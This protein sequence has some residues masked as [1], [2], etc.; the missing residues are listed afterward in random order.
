LLDESILAASEKLRSAGVKAGDCVGLHYPSSIDYIVF[1]YAVWRCGGCLIPL[2]MELA[3]QEKMEICRCLAMDKIISLQRS[4]G[5]FSSL[6]RSQ[7]ARLTSDAEIFAVRT[8]VDCP[9]ALHDLNPA[10]IRFSSGTTGMAKGVVLSHQTVLERITAANDVLQLGPSDRVLWVLSMSYHFTVSIVAYLTYGATIVLPANHFAAAIVEAV[11]AYQASVLYASPMHY[12]LLAEY[13]EAVPLPSLRLAI[14]TTSALST[15][16]SVQF[17]ERYGQP[18]GQALGIIE[19]GLPCIDMT[20]DSQK[21]KSVGR[22][23]PAYELRMNDVG[24]GAE[25][26]EIVVRGPGMLDAY[27]MPWQTRDEILEDGWFHT[28][29][30]GYVDRDGYL[31][32]NGRTKDVINVMGMKFFP[33]E[34]ERVL[35]SHPEVAAASVYSEP[36]GRWGEAVQARVVPHDSARPEHLASRLQTYCR[37]RIAAYKVPT[38]IEL[39]P[40][41]PRTASGKILHRAV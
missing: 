41:L 38:Q 27:Y 21:S 37:E 39:V 2:A 28:G 22:V 1:T 19:V 33:Q 40:T 4:T 26:K 31:Y 32:L 30:V 29:D 35:A 36:G 24:L 15:Q 25:T 23:L 10:F 9:P 17:Q 7:P 11:Q 12:A 13:S 3:T 6:V 8:T 5:I 18:L 20:G 14:S 16:T 34:V